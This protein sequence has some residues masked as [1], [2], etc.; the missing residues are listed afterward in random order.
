M[1]ASAFVLN[2]QA[3]KKSHRFVEQN[4]EPMFVSTPKANEVCFSPEERCDIKVIKF[5]E[6]AERSLDIAAFDVNLDQF[7]KVIVAKSGKIPVRVLVDRRQAQGDNSEVD[8][9]IKSGVQVRYGK[10]RSLMHNK[11]IVVDG[12]IIET[13][14]FNYTYNA[15]KNNNENQIYL[16]QSEIV[17]RYKKRFEKIWNEGTRVR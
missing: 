2:A 6:T 14:S 1:L 16:E 4:I 10:Q 5:V 15:S 8:F 12:R 3:R 9:L 7:V 17:E 11:F 13:G